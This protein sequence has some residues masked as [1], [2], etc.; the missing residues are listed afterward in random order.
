MKRITS[1]IT[2][3]PRLSVYYRTT[4]PGHP[5]CE[6]SASPHKNGP[7]A[8]HA[9]QHVVARLKA[10]VDAL[11]DPK[12]DKPDL[13]KQRSRWDWDLFPVHNQI[14]KWTI[15]RLAREHAWREAHE[16]GAGA[17]WFYMD[18]WSQ[19]LQRPDAHSEPGVDCLHCECSGL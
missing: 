9:E 10:Q 18:L 11:G 13:K 1:R 2:P 5:V 12:V 16:E 19:A 3:I 6:K 8:D 7:A 15:R 4:A 14:W 17:R